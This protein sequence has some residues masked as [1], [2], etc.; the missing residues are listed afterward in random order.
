MACTITSLMLVAISGV[1][2]VGLI[3][4][5]GS[6]ESPPAR[7]NETPSGSASTIWLRRNL[8]RSVVYKSPQCDSL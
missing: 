5:S 4:R 1:I 7:P 3:A 2:F 8:R 6:K